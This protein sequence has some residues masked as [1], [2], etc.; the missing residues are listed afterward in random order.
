MGFVGGLGVFQVQVFRV[1]ALGVSG[2]GF[3]V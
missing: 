1:W 2:F 3:T